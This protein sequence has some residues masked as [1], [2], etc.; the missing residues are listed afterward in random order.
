MD[1]LFHAV[2]HAVKALEAGNLSAAK[3]VL[4]DALSKRLPPEARQ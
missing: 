4:A 1:D 2:E 3:T